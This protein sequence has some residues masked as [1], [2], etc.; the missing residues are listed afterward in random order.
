[1]ERDKIQEKMGNK[2]YIGLLFISREA[3]PII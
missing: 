2:I 3:T 1:M